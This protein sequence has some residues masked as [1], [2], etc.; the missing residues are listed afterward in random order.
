MSA[1]DLIH[2][3]LAAFN[4]ADADA[5]MADFDSDA[6]W[7]TGDY[8]VP[9]GTLREFFA[10]AMAGLTPH[11]QL[12]R[13]IDGGAV[14]AAELTETWTSSEQDKTA[15]LIAVFDLDDQGLI[16]RAKIYREGSAD[17]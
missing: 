13:I 10:T 15:A 3:H 9:P 1:T 7:V 2:R 8:E 6:T 4:A 11:L 17:A 12:R 5:L 14:V 16:T